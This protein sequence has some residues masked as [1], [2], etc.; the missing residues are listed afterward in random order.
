[1]SQGYGNEE[2]RPAVDEEGLAGGELEDHLP[3]VPGQQAPEGQA[4]PPPPG[5]QGLPQEVDGR[6]RHQGAV[7]P[8]ETA[9]LDH[10]GS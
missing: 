10:A 4:E 7:D 2:S 5:P 1:V 3:E 6:Q 9:V 8:R